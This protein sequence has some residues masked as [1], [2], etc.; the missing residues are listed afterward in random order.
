[1]KKILLATVATIGLAGTAL[2]ADLRMPVKAPPVIAPVFNWSGCY[3]GGYVGGAFQD[4]DVTIYDRNG[5]LFTGAPN[6]EFARMGYKTDSS[7]L[8]GGTLGCNYQGF[9][10]PWVIGLE[11]EVGYLSLK[12]SIF[13]NNTFTNFASTKAGDLYALV[14]G[15]LGYSWDRALF[16]VKGGAAFIDVESSAYVTAA[17]ATLYTTKQNKAT[18]TIGAGL[19]WAFTPNWSVKAEYMY[20]G[21]D[22]WQDYGVAPRL[23]SQYEP[24]I[25]TAKVGLNYRFG[26]GK[27]PV[28]AKY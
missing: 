20:L 12:G 11:G 8:G 7:F 23:F 14:A 19:E 13:S 24:G 21:L 1:M 15:R 28:I 2:A 22:Y 26:F 18:W 27:A 25:H 4:R 9:G 3:L 6:T 10:S 17:P 5:L 16:Y